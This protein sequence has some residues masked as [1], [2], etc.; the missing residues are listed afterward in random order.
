MTGY[1][2]D[3]AGYGIAFLILN[4]LILLSGFLGGHI[5]SNRNRLEKRGYPES[6]I[7]FTMK[8]TKRFGWRFALVI[9]GLEILFS[10][11]VLIVTK[12]LDSRQFIG[13]ILIPSIIF[14]IPFASYYST[15]ANNEYKKMA[16]E[17]GHDIVVDFQHKLLKEIFSLPLEIGGTLL[18]LA[19][20][21]FFLPFRNSLVIYLYII[22]PWFFVA[23]LVF[24]KNYIK[25]VLKESYLM[26]GKMTIIY[27][28]ILIFLLIVESLEPILRGDSIAV[29]VSLAAICVFLAF[30]IAYYVPGLKRLK[31]RLENL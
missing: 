3:F 10:I 5:G 13:Y 18:V 30:K 29:I 25:P 8:F 23:T 7:Q 20:T 2:I 11:I 14:S 31:E 15:K 9:I 26:M 21:L 6:Y 22:L 16:I 24:T 27:Q 12:E 28:S 17:E 19:F 1:E 4:I